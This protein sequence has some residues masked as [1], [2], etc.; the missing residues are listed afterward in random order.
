MIDV[1]DQY[2]EIF[3]I[4]IAFLK[5][6]CFIHKFLF[7]LNL[8]LL[9]SS[10][11]MF[12]FCIYRVLFELYLRSASRDRGARRRSRSRSYSRNRLT[13]LFQF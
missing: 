12:I 1:I 13:W 11:L 7:I 6:C 2:Y 10:N 9:V 8:I 5:L 4:V 3:N